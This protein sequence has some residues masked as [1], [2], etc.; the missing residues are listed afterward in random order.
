MRRVLVDVE[1]DGLEYTKIHCIAVRLLNDPI[2]H[3]FTDVEDFNRWAYDEG[4]QFD[5]C[6]I[7]HNGCGFD[8]AVLNDLTDVEVD[9]SRCLDTAVLSRLEDYNRQHSLKDW[10]MRLGVYKGDYTGGW[11]VYTP[12]MGRYCKQDVVVLAEIYEKLRYMVEDP[13]WAEAVRIEHDV[14]NIC[15]EM[16]DD[17]FSFNEMRAK[18]LLSDVLTDMQELERE[19]AKSFPPK[20]TLAK[21]CKLRKKKDGDYYPN[22]IADMADPSYVRLDIREDDGEYDC[23]IDVPFNP[24]SPR[25]RIDV[26]WDAGWKPVEKTK[27][28]IQKLREMRRW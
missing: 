19:F 20:E 3:L 24:G 23:Y 9:L 14:A 8:F 5:A 22:V 16:Q 12:E 21:T 6:W 17:G 11:D 13:D 25:D 7:A 1:T 28:H 18:D 27:G 26:L 15:A 2:V 4:V 10:G